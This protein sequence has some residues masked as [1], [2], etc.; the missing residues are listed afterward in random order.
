MTSMTSLHNTSIAL[1]ILAAL[2]AAPASAEIIDPCSTEPA[3][4]EACAPTTA[5]ACTP[6]TVNEHV[7]PP[8]GPSLVVQGPPAG[9]GEASVQKDCH[10]S[11]SED[12]GDDWI[13]VGGEHCTETRASYTAGSFTVSFG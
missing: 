3:L 1:V 10:V 13:G 11:T 6:E 4:Q 7:Q 9:C 12:D 5:G 8:V 2:A